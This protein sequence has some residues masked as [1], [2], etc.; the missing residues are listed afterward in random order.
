MNTTQIKLT[1]FTAPNKP[2]GKSST[3][4]W[5]DFARLFEAPSEYESIDEL[6]LFSCTQFINNYRNAQNAG[7]TYAIV[8]DHDA[9]TMQPQEAAKILKRNG[10][11]A[12]IYTT[13]RHRPDKPRFRVIAQ[14]GRPVETSKH[15]YYVRVLNNLLHG[16]L[17][18]ESELAHQAWFYGKVQGG[19]YAYFLTL[20]GPIDY[21]EEIDFDPI[22]QVCGPSSPSS[23]NDTKERKRV[24]ADKEDS[25]SWIP[26]SPELP[27]LEAANRIAAMLHASCA[28]PDIGGYKVWFD[29]LAMV[30]S[31]GHPDAKQIARAWSK[32]GEK[33]DAKIFE[34]TWKSLGIDR[35]NLLTLGTLHKRATENGWI[36]PRTALQDTFGDIS[37]GQRFATKYRSQFL[38]VHAVGKWLR[39]DSVRWVSCDSGEE[40][41][42]AR[43]VVV[44]ALDTAHTALRADPTDKAK[45]N[46]SQA[47]AVHRNARRL[48]ALLHIASTENGM[49][50]PD[51]SWLDNDPMLL[52][53]R[54][55]I[56]NLKTGALLTPCPEMRISRQAGAAFNREAKCPQWIAF[57]NA[58]FNEEFDTIEF[59]QRAVG[60]ALTGLMD[61]EMLFFLLGAGANGK[62]VF[63]NVLHEIFGEYAVTV[64]STMLARDAK[65]SGSEAERE[66]ARLPG[67]RL[68]LIN[69]VG[70]NDVFDDQRLKELVS[71]E[72]ISARALYGESYD[73]TPSHTIF[74][75]GNHQPVALDAGDGFW[76]RI[77]LIKFKRQFAEGERI[78]DLDRRILES[79]RDGIL[80][81]AIE[82]CLDWQRNK[83]GMPKSIRNDGEEYRRDSD[84]LGE[85][86]DTSC[87]R[88]TTAQTPVGLLYDD[89]CEY[90]RCS[91]L[92]T[93]SKPVFSRQ[94]SQRGFESGRT[95]AARHIHGITLITHSFSTEDDEL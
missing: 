46:Y 54:N 34:R 83:L 41:K 28:D 63:A 17:A 48:D 70:I 19:D 76:R 74:I 91:G 7:M 11:A 95:K 44:D 81:W 29:H 27:T 50:I 16:S 3:I 73:F 56:V 14:L 45:N 60:Y 88:D 93:P 61:E 92:R 32:R 55:G 12:V 84:Q 10:I 5:L 87:R 47:L 35:P 8:G 80:G 77:A 20:G 15:L 59:V 37:N 9:G 33:Y 36:D 64:R 22:E 1:R 71:R 78:A 39:W 52:G 72:R 23:S 24:I 53:V 31:S 82:G 89:Y 75:R 69:E 18:R 51:P 40:L 90:L 68:V 43:S 58:I 30:H 65:G 94:L 26:P 57:L 85:W 42:A 38:F 79:E 4:S 25:L 21:V 67:A 86:L 49:S 2:T 66:K 13:R 6:P 62:S